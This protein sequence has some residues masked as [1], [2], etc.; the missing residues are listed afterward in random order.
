MDARLVNTRTSRGLC[1]G[2]DLEIVMSGGASDARAE[3]DWLLFSSLRCSARL[4]VGVR[5]V[6]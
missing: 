2:A 4:E 5:R 3:L 1:S 6:A